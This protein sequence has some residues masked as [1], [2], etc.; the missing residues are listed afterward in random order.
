MVGGRLRE[1]EEDEWI[2]VCE[3]RIGGG[4]G[5]L[6]DGLCL[7]LRQVDTFLFRDSLALT[8]GVRE[9]AIRVLSGNARHFTQTS[10]QTRKTTAMGK[11][12][13]QS[14]TVRSIVQAKS[15][16]CAAMWAVH[17]VMQQ[18]LPSEAHTPDIESDAGESREVSVLSARISVNER[19][20]DR[21]DSTEMQTL[22][23]VTEWNQMVTALDRL[24]SLL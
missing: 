22:D 1:K 2:D 13:V 17:Q 6:G 9:P 18:V 11:Y 23:V 19:G 20:F 4:Q 7:Q 16:R 8:A 15:N 5:A 14:G 12:Y 24:D 3:P 10:T 21:R